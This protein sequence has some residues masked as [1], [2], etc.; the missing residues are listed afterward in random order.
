MPKYII[1]GGKS[2]S[3][4]VNISGAKNSAL[5]ILAAS[6][7]AEGE[8]TIYNV[9]DI[10]DINK[11]ENILRQ[12]GASVNKKGNTV[13]INPKGVNTTILDPAYTKKIRA[14]IVLVGPMLS[15]YGEVT[16]TEPG[17]CLIGVRSINDHIDLFKQFDVEVIQEGNNF[18]FKGKPK[19]GEIILCKMSVTATEN[20]IMAAVLSEGKTFIRVAAA[21]PEIKDLANY[22]NSM[23]ADIKGAGTHDIEINGVKELKAVEHHVISDRIEAATYIMAAI[24]TNSEITVGPLIPNNLNIVLTKLSKI[25]ANFELINKDNEIFIKTL[26]HDQLKAID[27]DTRTYPG[28]PTDLQSVYAVLMTQ[29]YGKTRIFETLFE[30][31]FGY[32]EELK[33]MNAKI[34]IISPHIIEIYGYNQLKAQEIDA[35]DIRGGSALVLAAL[36]AN[37]ETVINHV[38]M[39]ERGYE[40][41]DKKLAM[42]SADIQRIE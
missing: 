27:I 17:G 10:I 26:H 38:D 7:M 28:F 36:V 5:K 12:I 19:A 15:K 40:N 3:G 16:I 18:I 6:I 23:G 8:S 20:A 13:T 22:L 25:G 32:I 24:I 1:R 4:A 39:I 37:G 2:L 11:M 41:M 30:S 34:E 33:R 21:E 35:F 9:P 29:A 14:S 42:I 31:R